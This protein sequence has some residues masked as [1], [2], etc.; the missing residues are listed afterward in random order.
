MGSK[1]VDLD[2]SGF[3]RPGAF[4]EQEASVK[5]V[6]FLPELALLTELRIRGNERGKLKMQMIE[7]RVQNARKSQ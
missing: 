2:G 5:K 4:L 1:I 7:K 3:G 6:C